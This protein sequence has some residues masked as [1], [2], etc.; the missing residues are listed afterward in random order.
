[1]KQHGS[2]LFMSLV[3]LLIL[4]IVGVTAINSSSIEE[5]IAGNYNNQQLAFYAAE[6]TLLEAEKYI[7]ETNLDVTE[8]T[9]EC[10]QGL[11]FS[12]SHVNDAASC[13]ANSVSPWREK[14]LWSNSSR[15]KKVEMNFG[16]ILFNGW[17]IIEFRCYLPKDHDGLKP[18]ITNINDWSQFF[19]IT[20]KASGAS[21]SARAM[22]QST[23]KKNN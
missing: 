16:G 21:K 5:K 23:Y 15:V 22:L 4:T 19:R 2:V 8:F 1:M 17:Y 11:C 14:D 3:F 12:G 18:D 20:V 9:S 10:N 13:S 6:A 7:S